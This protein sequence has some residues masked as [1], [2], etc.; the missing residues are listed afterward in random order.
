MGDTH[1]VDVKGQV[2]VASEDVKG[3]VVVASEECM[4]V[5]GYNV[6]W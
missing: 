2:V 4:S 5:V 6:R 1:H 3:Q